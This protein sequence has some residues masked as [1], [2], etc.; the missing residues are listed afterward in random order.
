MS[1]RRQ[2]VLERLVIATMLVGLVGIFQPWQIG[3]YNWGF[4]ILLVGTIG[5]III[6]H[7]T[8]ENE[9]EI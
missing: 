5:F 8:P 6:S 9:D 1:R 3:L 4:H 2:Q 7:V